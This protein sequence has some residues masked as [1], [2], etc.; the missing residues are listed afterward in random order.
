VEQSHAKHA[1]ILR[2]ATVGDI[3]LPKV[4]KNMTNMFP[5]YNIYTG[6]FE[7]GM[8]LYMI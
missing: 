4:L 1:L 8:K 7:H 2:E 6:T 3:R 5:K